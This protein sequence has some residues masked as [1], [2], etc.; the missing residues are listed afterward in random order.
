MTLAGVPYEI[1]WKTNLVTDNWRTYTNLI[2][3]GGNA[4]VCFTNVLPQAFFKILGNP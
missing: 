4:H 1:M 3:S 2:G